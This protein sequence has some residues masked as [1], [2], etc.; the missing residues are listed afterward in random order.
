MLPRAARV[1]R[2]IPKDCNKSINGY[3][4]HYMNND[5]F[6][7]AITQMMLV[8]TYLFETL[9]PIFKSI[10]VSYLSNDQK[11]IQIML[12]NLKYIIVKQQRNTK[13]PWA[14]E[15]LQKLSYV[16]NQSNNL[17]EPLCLF[18]YRQK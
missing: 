16:I 7:T 10:I 8:Y 9:E 3:V 15:L 2:I 4:R 12:N 17:I 11:K 5:V 1:Y 6:P 14:I 18:L 13:D